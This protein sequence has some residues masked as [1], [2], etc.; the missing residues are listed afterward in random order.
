L[1]DI[2]EHFFI[3][4]G[5]VSRVL[6]HNAGRAYKEYVDNVRIKEAKRLLRESHLPIDAISGEV[7]CANPR[8]FIRLFKKYT[9]ITP[10]EYRL[11]NK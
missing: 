6:K 10:S 5:H 4:Q 3:S 7:G 8:T 2:A 9:G 11:N 1:A